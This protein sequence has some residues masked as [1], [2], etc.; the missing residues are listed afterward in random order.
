[1]IRIDEVYYNTFH[2]WIEKNL[3]R[4]RMFFNDP[5]GANEIETLH[6]FG[7]RVTDVNYIVI[8][9]QVP[10]Y[11]DVQRP[12]FDEIVR[13]NKNITYRNS[14]RNRAI[15]TSDFQSSVVKQLEQIYNWKSYHYFF[16]GWAAMDRYR[17]YDK[18]FLVTP[19]ADRNPK[20][21]FINPNL[22]I[23]SRQ[24]HRVLLFYWLRKLG[25]KRD[26]TIFPRSCTVESIDIK[27]IAIKYSCL[28]PDIVDTVDS[29]GLPWN[30]TNEINYCTDLCQLNLFDECA[31]SLAYVV[32][33]T[34]CFGDRLHLTEKIFKPICMQMPFVLLSCRGSLEYL[35]RYGFKTFDS[36]WDES[37]DA[38]SDDYLR[39]KKVGK[40]LNSLDELSAT[41]RKQ[42]LRSCEPIIEHNYRHFYQGNFEKIL[43]QEF[44]GMLEQI[45][46][47]FKC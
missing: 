33:E 42:I 39:I 8:Y 47:D 2:P 9:D 5:P 16:H 44:T 4:T 29:A 22:T 36:V 32:S 11:L 17:G 43:W 24:E 37:Y 12:M 15:I 6:N 14:F 26:L 31:D 34:V 35:K 41:E 18:A 30:M 46:Q 21:S 27:D 7:E 20:Y 19:P 45:K 1:M 23:G 25:V 28:Y 40:L 10:I 13:L 38:E 3:P